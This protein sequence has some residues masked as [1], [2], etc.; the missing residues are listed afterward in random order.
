MLELKVRRLPVDRGH[1]GAI[2]NA[3]DRAADPQKD[4]PDDLE[5]QVALLRIELADHNSHDERNA[6][7]GNR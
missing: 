2:G 1:E 4:Q 5:D 3:A 7:Q 6:R